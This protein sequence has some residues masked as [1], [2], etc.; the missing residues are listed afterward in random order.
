MED[1]KQGYIG[2]A[3]IFYTFHII[4]TINYTFTPA[5]LGHFGLL[6]LTTYSNQTNRNLCFNLLL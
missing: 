4:Q 5:K 2:Y 1:I 6:E 3:G